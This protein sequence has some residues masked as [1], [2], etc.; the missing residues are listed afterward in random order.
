MVA[1]IEPEKC[2]VGR[3]QH[4]NNNYGAP[5]VVKLFL[6][7]PAHNHWRGDRVTQLALRKPMQ[8]E[9][10]T[11]DELWRAIA[12]NTTAMSALVY[13]RLELDAGG[14][15]NDVIDR[16]QLMQSNLETVGKLERKYR[17]YTD[18][19]RRRYP[20][21]GVIA[22]TAVEETRQVIRARQRDCVEM[23]EGRGIMNVLKSLFA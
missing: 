16:A 6:A 23:R 5:N 13:R 19:L 4:H 3:Q 17:A 20:A 1:E 9:N 11:D 22:V 2:R 7:A 14:T 21:P 10:L 18:E 12:H 15:R 8:C